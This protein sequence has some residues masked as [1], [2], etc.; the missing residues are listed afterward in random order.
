MGDAGLGDSV[1]VG[2]ESWERLR[3]SLR[4]G[5]HAGPVEAGDPGA[6]R[7]HMLPPRETEAGG[8]AHNHHRSAWAENP[9]VLPPAQD[10]P[11]AAGFAWN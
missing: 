1:S 6:G 10:L 11:S 8:P 7:Q 2:P 9:A 3:V 5:D 4:H